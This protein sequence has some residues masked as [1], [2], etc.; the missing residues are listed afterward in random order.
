[1]SE[2]IE[3]KIAMKSCSPENR[4]HVGYLHASSLTNLEMGGLLEF[5]VKLFEVPE[6]L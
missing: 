4:R 2:A 3:Q 5:M 1:V 6:K